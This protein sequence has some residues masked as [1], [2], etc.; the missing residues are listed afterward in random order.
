MIAI[1]TRRFVVDPLRMA[2]AVGCVYE[3]VSLSR[4][5]RL[6]TISELMQRAT[7]SRRARFASWFLVGYAAAHLFGVDR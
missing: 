6:P 1:T 3:L 5:N 7:T 2:V 4:R